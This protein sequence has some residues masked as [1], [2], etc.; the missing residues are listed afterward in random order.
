MVGLAAFCYLFGVILARGWRV[1]RTLRARA[2][3][4][5]PAAGSVLGT[6]GFLVGG[7]TQDTFADSEVAMPLWFATAILMTVDGE[8]LRDDRSARSA[9]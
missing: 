2:E 4:R 5:I 9:R 7:L 3:L 6:L 8:V 1:V